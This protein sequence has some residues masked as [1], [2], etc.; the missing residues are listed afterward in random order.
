MRLHRVESLLQTAAGCLT[1]C[2]LTSTLSSSEIVIIMALKFSC[3]DGGD[4]YVCSEG[5][6][7]V[8]CCVSDP[9]GTTGCSAGNLRPA[10]FP[11]E[12]YVK[13]PDQ[14]C[15]DG[16]FYTCGTSGFM[17]CCRGS[18]GC[19]GDSCPV[20]DLA[21]IH[22]TNN[23]ASAAPFLSLNS[24][25]LAAHT[26]TSDTVSSKTTSSD[27]STLTTMTT[28]ASLSST[29]P[30]LESSTSPS[31][32]PPAAPL[33]VGAVVGGAVGGFFV[34]AL[35]TLSWERLTALPEV[36]CTAGSL[37]FTILDLQRSESILIRGATSTIG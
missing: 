31:L 25:W 28:T 8:G 12:Q 9:C 34:L 4:F 35:L 32:P 33:N 13:F 19:E 5:G 36:Y 37:L 6:H 30:T 17:G 22:L 15:D 7:F 21:N 27:S 29:S 2:L 14:Q 18:Y 16:R 26:S 24:T 10:H 1:S 20:S 11:T 3:P 23:E